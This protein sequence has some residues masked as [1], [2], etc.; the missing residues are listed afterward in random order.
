[1]S[2]MNSTNTSGWGYQFPGAASG[3]IAGASN[4]QQYPNNADNSSVSAATGGVENSGF[5]GHRRM[6][7]DSAL[8]F[9]P[10]NSSYSLAST[11]D[12]RDTSGTISLQNCEFQ[13]H[14]K[15]V[16]DRPFAEP[17]PVILCMTV[18]SVKSIRV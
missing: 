3:Q 7:T 17:T 13:C 15:R 1:M 2:T 9:N 11:G 12:N 16:F 6:N 5:L 4:Y 10:Q 8:S 18:R 14:G